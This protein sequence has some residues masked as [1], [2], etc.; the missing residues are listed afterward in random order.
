MVV[1]QIGPAKVKYDVHKAL[2]LYHS[3]YFAKALTGPW[4]EAEQRVVS[5]DEVDVD[6]CKQPRRKVARCTY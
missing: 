1:V 3:E 5:L 6:E 4:V 2:I